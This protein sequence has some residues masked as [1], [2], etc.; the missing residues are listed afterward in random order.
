MQDT[1]QHRIALGETAPDLALRR[2]DQQIDQQEKNVM[3]SSL[4][5]PGANG[6]RSLVVPI[7]VGGTIAGG[8][9]LISAFLIY[10]WGVP[11]AI[12]GGL[13]GRQALHGGD[14]PWVLGVFLQ[15]FIALSAAAVYCLASNR[16]KF[17]K[18]NFIVCGLFYGIAVFLV[19]NLVVL[20][21]CALHVTGPYELRDLIRG[22]LIHMLIIGLPISF[23][24]WKFAK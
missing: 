17:L 23:S 20:P 19:M 16:M 8:L 5:A 18:E 10:G 12:A 22:L 1:G 4:S 13:L 24:A 9:D 14:G 2:R 21:L 7:F 15:F 6:K 3:I 11:R